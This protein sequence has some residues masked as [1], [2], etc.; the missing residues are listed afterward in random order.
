MGNNSSFKN[1]RLVF[2]SGSCVAG[3][4]TNALPSV[5]SKHWSTDRPSS[6]IM[7]S[8]IVVLSAEPITNGSG[9]YWPV[10]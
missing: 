5:R 6:T 1:V 4:G 2:L 3:T 9:L 10:W 7:R 8:P